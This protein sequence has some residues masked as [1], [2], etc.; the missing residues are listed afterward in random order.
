M[1]KALRPPEVL[2]HA[3][4]WSYPEATLMTGYSK[5][6]LHAMTAQG[7]LPCF[8]NLGSRK[9]GNEE[10]CRAIEQGFPLLDSEDAAA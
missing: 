6:H 3:R 4:F 7:R 5:A 9:L 10:T 2:K 8:G 1:K